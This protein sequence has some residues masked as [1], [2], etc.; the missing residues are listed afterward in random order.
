MINKKMVML[1]SV[2]I[3][4]LVIYGVN[5]TNVKPN[6]ITIKKKTTILEDG[7][8]VKITNQDPVI[9]GTIAGN[10]SD[11]SEEDLSN[12]NYYIIPDGKTWN[13][14]IQELWSNI[15]VV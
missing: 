5:R 4:G 6:M 13:E 14:E 12:L 7:L 8:R 3:G 10:D 11:N 1:V 2:I 15:E 9:Y